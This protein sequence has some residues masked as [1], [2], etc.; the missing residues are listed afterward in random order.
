METQYRRHFNYMSLG[1]EIAKA[2]GQ[3]PANFPVKELLT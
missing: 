3:C 2:M 1:C